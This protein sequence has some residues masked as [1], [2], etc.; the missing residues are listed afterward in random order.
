MRKNTVRVTMDIGIDSLWIEDGFNLDKE[1]IQQCMYTGI[2]SALPYSYEDEVSVKVI[3][4]APHLTGVVPDLKSIAK[5]GRP[6]K[7]C[8]K[9]YMEGIEFAGLAYSTNT[10]WHLTEQGQSVLDNHKR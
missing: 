9:W 5:N 7:N 4:I 1:R 6:K 2:S 3:N 8:P 10:G